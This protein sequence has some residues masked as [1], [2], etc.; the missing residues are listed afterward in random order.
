MQAARGGFAAGA[1][2]VLLADVRTERMQVSPS[3]LLVERLVRAVEG[4]EEVRQRVEDLQPAPPGAEEHVVKLAALY[5]AFV[6][7]D[8][9]R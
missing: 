2:E 6:G 1:G 3:A 8:D 5:R 7:D 9:P 4:A